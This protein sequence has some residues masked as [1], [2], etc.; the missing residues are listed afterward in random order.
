M[1]IGTRENKKQ[2]ALHT[3]GKYDPIIIPV[4]PPRAEKITIRPL[5][6]ACCLRGNELNITELIAG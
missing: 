3:L 6:G 4:V 2:F 5:I 1:L